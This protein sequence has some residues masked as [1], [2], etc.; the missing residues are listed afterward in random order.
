MIITFPPQLQGVEN[1]YTR[2][3]PMI[4]ETL[5]ALV[6]GKLKDTSF[7]YAG[8]PLPSKP[9]DVFVFIVG[10]VTYA[11]AHVVAQFNKS[12][13]G[14]RVVLGSN[15]VINSEGYGCCLY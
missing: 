9:Q 13:Q 2:H 3:K 10:G 1:V 8:T 7:P 15:Y 4:A 14:M 11:E 12:N 5:E 6:K